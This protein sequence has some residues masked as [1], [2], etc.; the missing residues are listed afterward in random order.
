MVK[1]NTAHHIRQRHSR[2]GLYS[3]NLAGLYV[4]YLRGDI[5]DYACVYIDRL[6]Y[7]ALGV[8]GD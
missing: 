4:D 7:P 8:K 2:Q 1:K 3:I 5:T 6:A